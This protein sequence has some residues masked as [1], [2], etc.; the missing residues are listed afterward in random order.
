[1]ERFIEVVSGIALVLYVIYVV[2]MLAIISTVGLFLTARF[3]VGLV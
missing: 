3:L 2:V 1:M